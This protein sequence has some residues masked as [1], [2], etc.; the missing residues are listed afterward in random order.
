[1]CWARSVPL[2]DLLPP[3][4]R[5]SSGPTNM[6]FVEGADMTC[7]MFNVVVLM[8]IGYT[9]NLLGSLQTSPLKRQLHAVQQGGR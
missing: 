9:L 1:M 6:A 7:V 8:T 3:H 5:T 2:T 4:L